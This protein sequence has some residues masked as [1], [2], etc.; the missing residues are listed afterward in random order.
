MHASCWFFMCL[1]SVFKK[2]NCFAKYLCSLHAIIMSCTRFRVNLR[3]LFAWMSRIPL[4]KTGVIKCHQRDSFGVFKCSYK[5]S[6]CGFKSHWITYG[7][8]NEF[9][10]H[11][12]MLDSWTINIIAYFIL[13]QKFYLHMPKI[14]EVSC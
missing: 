2:A 12:I 13:I 6:A 1:E 10:K 11:F 5:L 8:I 14:C 7:L 3:S 4:L 9:F